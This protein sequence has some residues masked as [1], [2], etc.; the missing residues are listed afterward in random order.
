[1]SVRNGYI[2]GALLTSPLPGLQG[3]FGYEMQKSRF[4]R[5]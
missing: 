4:G 3:S 2:N 5:G 1:M